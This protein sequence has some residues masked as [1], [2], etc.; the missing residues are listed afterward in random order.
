[1]TVGCSGDDRQLEP[2]SG[3]DRQLKKN[4][5]YNLL[6]YIIIYIVNNLLFFSFF[7]LK[8]ILLNTNV[9]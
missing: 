2:S 6:I 7:I 1:M 3:Y 8:R 5:T 4:F 9:K